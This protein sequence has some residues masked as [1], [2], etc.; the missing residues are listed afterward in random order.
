MLRSKLGALT[1]AVAA[2]TLVVGS[3]TL[4]GGI[5][6]ETALATV[7]PVDWTD[8]LEPVIEPLV[9]IVFSLF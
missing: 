8:L 3:V 7:K 5:D 4:S 1:V 6:A 2:L 9:D